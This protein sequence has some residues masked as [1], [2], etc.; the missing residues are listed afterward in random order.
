MLNIYNDLGIKNPTAEGGEK[1]DNMSDRFD[2]Q[3][4]VLKQL[5]DSFNSIIESQLNNLQQTVTNSLLAANNILKDAVYDLLQSIDPFVLLKKSLDSL[6]K[7]IEQSLN[8]QQD[9]VYNAVETIISEIP[10]DEETKNKIITSKEFTELKK[11]EPW[12]RDQKLCLISIIIMFLSL[13]SDWIFSF[14]NNNEKSV[15]NV[16]INV[17][18][19]NY[20]DNE[21]VEKLE[22]AQEQL[23][24][25]LKKIVES[26]ENDE[27]EDDSNSYSADSEEA[28]EPHQPQ[29]PETPTEN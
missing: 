26:F 7:A 4:Y 28:S 25:I 19:N 29:S 14:K 24:K 22:N 6:Q 3:S 23:E 1:G 27:M 13:F 20:A 11:K 8:P 15:N 10:V 2:F 5:Q 18:A 12:T 9:I 21:Q 16:T 17:N